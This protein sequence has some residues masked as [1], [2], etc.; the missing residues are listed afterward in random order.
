MQLSRQELSDILKSNKFYLSLETEALKMTNHTLGGFLRGSSQNIDITHDAVGNAIEGLL[1]KIKDGTYDGQGAENIGHHKNRIRRY[2]IKSI[3]SYL[4]DRS[5][6]WGSNINTNAPAARARVE[7]PTDTNKTAF[8]DK[9]HQDIHTRSSKSKFKEGAL[10]ELISKVN[11]SDDEKWIVDI[12]SSDIKLSNCIGRKESQSEDQDL[13]RS[14]C[15]DLENEKPISKQKPIPNC[16][17]HFVELTF[18]EIAQIYGG[19]PDTY[20]KRFKKAIDKLQAV[21]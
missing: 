15:Q 1:K 8:F 13:S 12:R 10:D 3:N 18:T 5:R 16:T 7:A 21:I 20:Q 17:C 4:V 19:K 6:R 2:I 14:T 11:L 9:L